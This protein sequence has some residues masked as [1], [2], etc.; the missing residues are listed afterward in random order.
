MVKSGDI[1]ETLGTP[2]LDPEASGG[3]AGNGSQ[4]RP[5]N[6]HNRLCILARPR[7]PSDPW[8]PARSLGG[9]S[10]LGLRV[11]GGHRLLGE[12]CLEFCATR[13]AVR[14]EFKKILGLYRRRKC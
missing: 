7:P 3:R 1:L 11:G 5:G 8:T 6:P 12:Y 4:G 13:A 2:D 9:P 14:S 10:L